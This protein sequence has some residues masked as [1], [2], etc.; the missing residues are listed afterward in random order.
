MLITHILIIVVLLHPDD[1]MVTHASEIAAFQDQC[2][3]CST[4]GNYYCTASNKCFT[5]YFND[6]CS[7]NFIS[8]T[9]LCPDIN[10]GYSNVCELTMGIDSNEVYNR[11]FYLEPRTACA[12]TLD[13]Y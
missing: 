3:P 2:F 10:I 4:Q 6:P 7:V 12:F 11:V 5:D 9:S 13:G 8:S 1:Q